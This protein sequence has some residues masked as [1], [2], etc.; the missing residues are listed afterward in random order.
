MF[1]IDFQNAVL[2]ELRA[3][4]RALEEKKTPPTSNDDEAFLWAEP[5]TDSRLKSSATQNEAVQPRAISMQEADA[6]RYVVSLEP[7]FK[8]S[9]AGTYDWKTANHAA[10]AFLI[11]KNYSYAR[12]VR[13]WALRQP[14]FQGRLIVSP[15]MFEFLESSFDKTNGL[16]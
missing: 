6:V 10:M 9:S 8:K 12:A 14:E 16:D 11:N 15:I 3:I 1:P 5:E 4:R 2:T 13:D 7:I